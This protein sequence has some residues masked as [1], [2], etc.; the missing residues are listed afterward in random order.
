MIPAGQ[1]PEGVGA[2]ATA[3]GMG[4]RCDRTNPLFALLAEFKASS[5]AAKNTL[6]NWRDYTRHVHVGGSKYT[7]QLFERG[8]YTPQLFESG[9]RPN[10][11]MVA[12][13]STN[14]GLKLFRGTA[15]E[16]YVE[17]NRAHDLCRTALPVSDVQ[18]GEL[19]KKAARAAV[20][21]DVPV[22]V[23]RK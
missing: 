2:A 11:M 20:G 18:Q 9:T 12:F 13:T 5:Q 7:L 8:N 16:V 21:L 17:F 4:D 23:V 3:G 1:G 14:V 22:E 15:L 6:G 10:N 19:L